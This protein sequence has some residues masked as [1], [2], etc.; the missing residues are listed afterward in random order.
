[1]TLL[2]EKWL[3]DMKRKV[4]PGA[5]TPRGA[6]RPRVVPRLEEL[7]SRTV[8]SRLTVTSA[9]D[10]GSAGTLRAEIAAANSG[11]TINFDPSLAGQTITLTTGELFIDTSLDIEGLGPDQLTVSGGGNSRVV[12]VS[13]GVNVTLAGMTVTGGAANDTLPDRFGG[14]IL[15]DGS[16]TLNNCDISGNVAEG[17]SGYATTGGGGSPAGNGLGGGIYMAEGTLTINNSS[18]SSNEARGGTGYNW[19]PAG[20]GYGGGLYIAGGTVS[21]NNSVLTGNQAVGGLEY[22]ESGAAIGSGQGYG[23]GIYN[24]SSGTLTLSSTTVFS[25]SADDIYNLGTINPSTASRFVLSGFPSPTTAGAAGTITVTALNA[26]GS[27]DTGYTGTVHFTSSD[28]QAALPTDY[29][30]T[31]ADNGTHT[32]RATLK[33]AGTRS[34]TVAD[35]EIDNISGAQT[36]IT[37]NAAT[38]S[39]L[40]VAGFPSAITA[41][42]AGNVTVTLRDPYGNI[43]SGYTGIVHFTSSDPQAALPGDY[44]FTSADAGVHT[45]RATLKTVGTQ[46]ITATDMATASL[47]GADSGITVNAAAAK[48]ILTAPASVPAGASFSLTLIVEDAYGNVVTNYTGM[49]HFSSTDNKATL[50]GN[51]TFTAADRGVHTFPGLVL[52]KKGHQKITLTDTLTSSLTGNVIVDVL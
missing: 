27:T 21:I 41:G 33:T 3:K 50:P 38:A 42:V 10:D 37:V 36:G 9:A 24:D 48:F 45:F 18:L 22:P 25:N 23:G 52:R 46:S 11:D 8:P 14:G 5:R 20:N 28:P 16:L 43:A 19:S 12:A 51:Y 31:A 4:A 7:E 17:A 49:V 40:S 35:A 15:N 47:T 29:T 1:M 34:I 13:S 30:F 32:F 2:L 39:T 44:T 6:M 26:D